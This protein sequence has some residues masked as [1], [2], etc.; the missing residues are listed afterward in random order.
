MSNRV[1]MID[2][3]AEHAACQFARAISDAVI[4]RIDRRRY[5]QRFRSLEVAVAK[6]GVAD[7]PQ[8]SRDAGTDPVTLLN[9]YNHAQERI[10]K[11]RAFAVKMA[12]PPSGTR[13]HGE[14]ILNILDEGV[15]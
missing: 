11:V 14:Q 9:A 8:T 15:K 3:V 10:N 13:W 5:D 4:E 12:T 6:L 7:E 1:E 2:Q